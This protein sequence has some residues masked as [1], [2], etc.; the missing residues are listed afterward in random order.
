VAKLLY[1]RGYRKV[2]PLLGGFDG[3]KE[4]G[5]PV[6]FMTIRPKTVTANPPANE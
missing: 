3:W 1:D 6:E 4:A 5:L 2:R